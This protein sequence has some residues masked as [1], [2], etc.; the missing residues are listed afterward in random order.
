M[1]HSVYLQCS[2]QTTL[3]QGGLDQVTDELRMAVLDANYTEDKSTENL[4]AVLNIFERIVNESVVLNN[5]VSACTLP[6]TL[7]KL[8]ELASICTLYT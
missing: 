3:T 1:Y 2:Q 8:F 6:S 4:E 7:V 5:Q